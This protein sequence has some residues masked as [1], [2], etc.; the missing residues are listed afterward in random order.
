LLPDIDYIEEDKLLEEKYRQ[1]EIQKKL[2]LKLQIEERIKDFKF[3]IFNNIQE[4]ILVKKLSIDYEFFKLFV[5]K[6]KKYIHS[7]VIEEVMNAYYYMGTSIQY[8]V[9]IFTNEMRTFINVFA[10]IVLMSGLNV[11]FMSNNIN[12][13]IFFREYGF[14]ISKIDGSLS[15]ERKYYFFDIFKFKSME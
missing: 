11:I 10:S 14:V 8:G 4:E 1:E 12:N 5:L 15:F 7:Y 2:E 6:K 13:F 9:F 3:F